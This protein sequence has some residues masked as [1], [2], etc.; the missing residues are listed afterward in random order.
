MPFALLEALAAGRPAL[1]TPETNLGD[2]ITS[3][4][5]GVEVSGEAHQV[6]AGI[7][8]ILSLPRD[9]HARMQHQARRL[10]RERF[11]WER[12]IGELAA[13]YRRIAG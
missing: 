10:I 8:L 13:H 5:A 7:E 4:G 3:Y 11:A 12:V 9:E 1:V 2:L 6:A